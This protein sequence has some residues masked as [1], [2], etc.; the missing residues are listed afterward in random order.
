MTLPNLPGSG[1]LTHKD[2]MDHLTAHAIAASCARVPGA[3][4]MWEDP[5]PPWVFAGRMVTVREMADLIWPD[6]TA[7]KT[8]F[9]LKWATWNEHN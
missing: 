4:P 3:V 7:D 8:A 2:N 6:D 5:V 1:H 9:L